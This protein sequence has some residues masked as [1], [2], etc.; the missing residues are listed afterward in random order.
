MSKANIQEA[1]NSIGRLTN[2]NDLS[3]NEENKLRFFLQKGRQAAKDEV[4]IS[5]N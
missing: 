3:I 4:I 1:M 2:E 5:F